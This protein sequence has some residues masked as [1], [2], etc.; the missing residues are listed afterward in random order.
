[1]GVDFVQEKSFYKQEQG[2]SKK[3]NNKKAFYW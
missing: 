1:M 3:E 2:K